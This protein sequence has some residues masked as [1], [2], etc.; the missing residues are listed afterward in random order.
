MFLV[1]LEAAVFADPDRLLDMLDTGAVRAAVALLHEQPQ[2]AEPGSRAVVAAWARMGGGDPPGAAAELR[3]LIPALE[4]PGERRVLGH[5]LLALG[6]ASVL[7]GA[8]DPGTGLLERAL[9]LLAAPWARAQCLRFLGLALEQRGAWEGAAARYGSAA[10]IYAQIQNDYGLGSA[11]YGAATAHSERA[12]DV[13]AMRLMN[14]AVPA[15]RRSGGGPA[16]GAA[17]AL[18]AVLGAEHQDPRAMSLIEEAENLANNASMFRSDIKLRRAEVCLR[19]G[20]PE[21][22]LTS[23]SEALALSPPDA[24][25]RSVI[26]QL[27]AHALFRLGRREEAQ[28]LLEEPGP[29]AGPGR[30]ERLALRIR[31]ASE[32]EP[33]AVDRLLPDLERLVRA[34]VRRRGVAGLLREAGE[35]L[36]AAA[37]RPADADRAVWLLQLSALLGAPLQATL[38]H[39]LKAQGARVPLGPLWLEAPLGQGGMGEVWSARHRDGGVVAVKL[40]REGS[41]G[42][43]AAFLEA[44]LQALARLDHPGVVRLLAAL[45]LEEVASW[46]LDRPVGS[47]ALVMELVPGGSL[48]GRLSG[49]RWPALR[50]LLGGLLAGLA[51]AH[52]R[53]VLHLDIKPGNILIDE[54]DGTLVPRLADFGLTNPARRAGRS[55]V[56]GTPAYMAPEQAWVDGPLGPATD[57]YAVGCLAWQLITGNVPYDAEDPVEILA[58]HR[59]GQLP[60]FRPLTPVPEG[61]EAWL[62]TLLARRPEQRYPCA[63]DAAWALV[64]L[65]E[66]QGPATFV[67]ASSG[68]VRTFDLADLSTPWPGLPH[69]SGAMR[70][71]PPVDRLATPA[72]LPRAPFP[73]D[74]RTLERRRSLPFLPGAG[75]GLF[76][77]R[78][79]PLVGREGERDRLWAALGALRDHGPGRLIW[80]IGADG[81]GRS[82]LLRW[83]GETALATGATVSGHK[84]AARSSLFLMD[85]ADGAEAVSELAARVDAGALVVAAAGA[86]P[87]DAPEGERIDLGPLSEGELTLLLDDLLPLD[88]ALAGRLATRA[89]GSPAFAVG[90]LTELVRRD[91][92][93]PGPDGFCARLAEDLPLPQDLGGLWAERLETLAPAG[94][95]RR[96]AWEIAAVLGESPSRELWKGICDRVGLSAD[97]GVFTPL[98]VA[99]WLGQEGEHLCFRVPALREAL[100]AGAEAA[101][102]A[103]V[104][105][106]AAAELLTEHGD[107]AAGRHF[108]LAG[109]HV[110]ALAPLRRA[111]ADAVNCMQL[112][113]CR[114][115]VALWERSADAIGLALDDPRRASVVV[116]RAHLALHSQED[117]EGL[118]RQGL[119]L[120]IGRDAVIEAQLHYTRGWILARSGRH[121]EADPCFAEAI[122]LAE[123]NPELVA[124]AQLG[125][126]ASLFARGVD[127]RGLVE[128]ARGRLGPGQEALGLRADACLGKGLR[129]LGF[130]AE[131]QRWLSR[132]AARA[133]RAGAREVEAEAL[134]ELAE[135]SWEE[136]SDSESVRW[137]ERAVGVLSGTGSDLAWGAAVRL[138]GFLWGVGRE[139]EARAVLA[140]IRQRFLGRLRGPVRAE[141][142]LLH[143]LLNGQDVGA[144]LAPGSGVEEAVRRRL[145][146]PSSAR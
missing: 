133:E 25:D 50:A 120:V 60:E 95:P 129:R 140:P 119:A 24:P 69:A 4:A 12:D 84:S 74:W 6:V 10:E 93:E 103:A 91:A 130:P 75:E 30:L 26:R 73:P 66:V 28:A 33:A 92:L 138:G 80:V 86:V 104:W 101:G 111:A 79:G 48:E 97:E 63:A 49:W 72:S 83:L 20:M 22:S 59:A 57:L 131:A 96:S 94:S 116:V 90:L 139:E 135:L 125:R 68:I 3:P 132:A 38:L 107:V 46:M 65:A 53:E 1:R 88:P 2:V 67:S 16:L 70:P 142:E 123:G 9:S 56:L 110:E 23:A 64:Q 44:E 47:M 108:A 42:E 14:E 134:A 76:A 127:A 99:G 62:R 115:L 55:R 102:R 85:D 89:A 105:H 126:A 21:E 100:R 122:R 31:I 27:Q 8:P 114:S 41:T 37:L 87:D 109:R 113:S 35:V 145:G 45:R 61:L 15:L 40:L 71:L 137:M 128:E 98:E 5:G 54:V 82:A 143:G 32:G 39:R 106:G 19:M 51:H 29:T 11:L 17:L 52:A 13:E 124:V 43:Q 36:A 144:L 117:A 77:W 34:G 7:S 78:R 121:T 81:M 18:L 141:W 58:L 136:G 146:R 112:E 118:L